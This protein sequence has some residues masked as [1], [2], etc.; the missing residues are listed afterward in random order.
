MFH[1][2][3]Y[4]RDSPSLFERLW[5]WH[6]D[7]P[8]PENLNRAARC[9]MYVFRRV[10]HAA[11]PISRF[12]VPGEISGPA[13]VPNDR[14]LRPRTFAPLPLEEAKAWFDR[15]HSANEAVYQRN[16]SWRPQPYALYKDAGV[17]VEEVCLRILGYLSAHSAVENPI[18]LD[19]AVQGG[20]YLLRE[21]VF[22]DGHMMLLGHLSPDFCYTYAGVALLA[23]WNLDRSQTRY[24]EAARKIG[25]RLIEFHAAGSVNH[26]CAPAQLLGPLYRYTGEQSYLRAMQTRVLKHAL[27]F[28]LRSGDWNGYQ[29]YAW[30]QAVILRSLVETYISLPFTL[31]NAAP[32]DKLAKAIVAGTNWF[33]RMQDESG[34]LPISRD[35]A[36]G[37]PSGDKD[38]V[39][40]D[41]G[42]FRPAPLPR[43]LGH[44]AYEIEAL[45]SMF[46]ILGTHSVL[47]TLH[48]YAARLARSERLWRLE[49]NTFGAGRYLGLRNRTGAG[50]HPQIF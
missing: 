37:Y 10:A 49:F 34:A 15:V 9:G 26:A 43:Y 20:D 19:R 3:R 45:S 11:R 22:A 50:A 2:P 8:L 40:F 27:P 30:Y 18:F 28:Q 1:T 29:G 23:L 48:G 5:E 38:T 31:R 41:G 21:R 24:F 4:R 33:I 44:G 35:T 16:G 17:S 46:E 13:Q 12:S 14:F 47:P 39:V 32:K 25:D 6:D 36:S 7:H 42:R